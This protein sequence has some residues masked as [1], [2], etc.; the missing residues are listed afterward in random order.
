[1]KKGEAIERAFRKANLIGEGADLWA[2]IYS[3]KAL[4]DLPDSEL[5]EIYEELAARLGFQQ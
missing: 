1:M 3:Y 2:I 5:D 4:R